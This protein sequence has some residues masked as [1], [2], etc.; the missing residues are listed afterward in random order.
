[1]M[2]IEKISDYFTA[3]N[4]FFSS[5]YENAYD[6]YIELFEGFEPTPLDTYFVVNYS[7]K[8]VSPLVV[9]TEHDMWKLTHIAYHLYISRWLKVKAAIEAEYDVTQ[10]Y[11]IHLESELS[12]EFTSNVDSNSTDTDIVFGFDD[13]VNGHND[14]KNVR[15]SDR[16][17]ANNESSE[18][19][20]H[21]YGNTGN[22]NY[23]SLISAELELRRTDFIHSVI[24]DLQDLFTLSIYEG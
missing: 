18:R 21:R 16:D 10:P 4:G 5:L 9:N 13:N 23:A 22:R 20:Q 15:I 24:N 19:S 12:R 14:N 6:D 17:V 7:S 8:P 3:T 1:M 11:N 2:S